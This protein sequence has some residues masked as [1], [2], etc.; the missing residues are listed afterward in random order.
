MNETSESNPY[1]D[2]LASAGLITHVAH[3]LSAGEDADAQALS[4]EDENRILDTLC[5]ILP[6]P[7]LRLSTGLYGLRIDA[8][9]GDAQDLE[10][11]AAAELGDFSVHFEPVEIAADPAGGADAAR[12]LSE[13]QAL[14]GDL[15]ERDAPGAADLVAQLRAAVSE[16]IAEAAGGA[17]APDLSPQLEALGTEIA[18]LRSAIA[19][20]TQ[21]EATRVV[22]DL[23]ARLG[24]TLEEIRAGMKAEGAPSE[25]AEILKELKEIRSQQDP[26]RLDALTQMVA[27]MS[28]YV[29]KVSDQTATTGPVLPDSLIAGLEKFISQPKAVPIL[30]MMAE[31]MTSLDATVR[32]ALGSGDLGAMQGDLAQFLEKMSAIVEEGAIG[33]DA[34]TEPAATAHLDER[35]EA[36]EARLE[37]LLPLP[38]RIADIVG[39]SQATAQ[40]VMDRAVPVLEEIPTRLADLDARLARM[41]QRLTAEPESD[42]GT[43]AM[44]ETILGHL[45][46][47]G[48]DLQTLSAPRE[49]GAPGL[50]DI[51]GKVAMIEEGL[52]R[53]ASTPP[54]M[55]DMSVE[56]EGMARL[57]VGMQSMLRRLDAQI[58]P[59]E[60]LEPS[61]LMGQIMARLETLG[62]GLSD[63][64]PDASDPVAEVVQ[65]VARIEATLGDLGARGADDEAGAG[66]AAMLERL[67]AQIAR[68][69][70]QP[71]PDAAGA[72]PDLGPLLDELAALRSDLGQGLDLS[73]LTTRITALQTAVSAAAGDGDSAAQIGRL[74]DHIALLERR[75]ENAEA[76]ITAPRAEAGLSEDLMARLDRMESRI[77]GVSERLA[78]AQPAAE[79]LETA[80]D[81]R[82]IL[83]E[84]LATLDRRFER[85]IAAE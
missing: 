40:A 78:S 65:A 41:E 19:T 85:A 79:H 4:E 11:A 12:I 69:E 23:G 56:R 9:G 51:P 59:M 58:R 84:F 73:D 28:E 7:V 38:D 34:A 68:L 37:T 39:H 22:E 5:E 33:T 2:A 54:R 18:G 8:E 10:E 24:E 74:R 55:P 25:L 81:I 6:E 47:L 72:A 1:L 36:L 63:L 67:E 80:Q 49:D 20:A 45:Q 43:G 16:Q 70:T 61:D 77:E 27:R 29:S 13:L 26:T 50:A 62:T 48:R 64:D 42:G 75:L 57:S 14:R 3:V 44:L 30:E 53:L 21:E 82:L 15:A 17:P 60:D 83:A 46:D 76:S 31:R 66:L 32:A 71:A 35:I 52:G